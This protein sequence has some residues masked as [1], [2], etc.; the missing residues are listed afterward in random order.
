MGKAKSEPFSAIDPKMNG[1]ADGDF[2]TVRLDISL[3]IEKWFC[4]CIFESIVY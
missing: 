1:D 4:M 2:K 3:K